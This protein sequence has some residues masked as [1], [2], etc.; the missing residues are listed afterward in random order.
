M[1]ISYK[2]N[3]SNKYLAFLNGLLPCLIIDGW[4]NKT[5]MRPALPHPP[6]NETF[7]KKLAFMI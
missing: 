1:T 6:T 4:V 5:L 2:N 7:G 3:G